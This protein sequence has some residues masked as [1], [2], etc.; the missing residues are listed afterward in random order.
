MKT[1]TRP[2]IK[3]QKFVPN[4]CVVN[5]YFDFYE[6]EAWV[7]DDFHT[8]GSN[9]PKIFGYY[10]IHKVD[11]PRTDPATGKTSIKV[12]SGDI[13]TSYDAFKPDGSNLPAAGDY[14][15]EYDDYD[16]IEVEP[17]PHHS[18]STGLV[19]YVITQ[20]NPTI[21]ARAYDKNHS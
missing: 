10:D 3:V 11:W 1:W 15:F 4:F 17:G 9:D 5:C 19:F 18:S 20:N 7:E 6:G 16:L 14:N 12:D 8:P 13:I 21:L 2:K